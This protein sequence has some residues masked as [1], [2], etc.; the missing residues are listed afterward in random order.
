MDTMMLAHRP[1]PPLSSYVETLWYFDGYR[2]AQHKERVLP[3]G[4]FQLIIDLSGGSGVVVGP[5]TRYIVI[6]AAAIQTVMGVAFWP[7]GA[8]PFLDPPADE[9]SNQ[10][11]PLDL[12][13]GAS[14]NTLRDR[15]QE[16]TPVA[17]KF[18]V[19]EAAL[20]RRFRTQ[21]E[22]HAAVRFA[23]GKFRRAPHIHSVLAVTKDSGLSRRR[24][25]QLFREQV[26]LTPKLHC[27]LGRFQQVVQQIA[28]GGPVDW[29]DV[30]LA[31]GYCDQAH[32]AN[33]FRDFSGLSPGSFLAA[34]RPFANH[35]V[36]D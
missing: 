3:N 25:S 24:L 31:G 19:L 27:R 16:A 28:S 30:A 13:W 34:E 15:L 22:L 20:E 17:E 26:G 9:F 12:A 2:T 11:V 14:V 36:T 29:A 10:I 1:A 18:R 33:E 23:L 32:L 4:Q 8:R 5:R 6:D 7:G 35:V 21:L